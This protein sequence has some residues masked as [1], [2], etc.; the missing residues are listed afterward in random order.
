M[1]ATIS[2]CGAFRYTLHRRIPSM[3]RWV[4]PCLFI[5]LNPSK[6]DAQDDDPTIRR[7]IAFAQREQC[8]ELAVVNLYGLRATKPRML[9][10]SDD[11]IGPDNDLYIC[12]EVYRC[13]SISGIIIAAWGAHPMAPKRATAVAEMVGSML[14]LGTTASGQP[15]HPLFVRGDAPLV[16][17]SPS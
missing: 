14:C 13:R 17:W 10:L 12:R 4:R 16:P 9:G 7:C 15:R 6:A 8:T 3:L 2:D 5:M 11:P 1:S